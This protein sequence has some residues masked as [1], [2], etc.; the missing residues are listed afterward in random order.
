[1]PE[2]KVLVREGASER[3]RPA[4]HEL[5]RVA[6]KLAAV[7]GTGLFMVGVIDLAILW[8]P[9]R[10]GTAGWEFAAVSRTFTNMPMIT[11][12][13][14][15]APLAVGYLAG[16]LRTGVVKG[17]AAGYAFGVLVMVVL[18]GLYILSGVEVWQVTPPEGMSALKRAI[19]KNGVEMVVY[20]GILA[21]AAVVSWRF[22]KR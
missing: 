15:M 19:L 22:G 8:T 18:A 9:F 14:L 12:G 21:S 7:F 6:A 5:G 10:F 20:T 2:R 3:R 13:A 4:G 11:L 16:G 17:V 1:M